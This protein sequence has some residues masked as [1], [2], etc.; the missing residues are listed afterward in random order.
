MTP[1][2]LRELAAAEKRRYDWRVRHWKKL[3][4]PEIAAIEPRDH[5]KPLEN[6]FAHPDP[7][8]VA[9]KPRKPKPMEMTTDRRYKPYREGRQEWQL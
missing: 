8:S 7:F 3:D 1:S 6:P 5:R 4:Q 9:S 2:E